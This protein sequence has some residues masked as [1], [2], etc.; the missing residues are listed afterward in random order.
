MKDLREQ[1]GHVRTQATAIWKPVLDFFHHTQ[2]IVTS[3]LMYST[4]MFALIL[5]LTAW[6]KC[7]G[8]ARSQPES[9]TQHNQ[10]RYLCQHLKGV[11]N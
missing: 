8:V 9:A 2:F 10:C 4:V 7:A 11:M 1:P 6:L 3:M 5:Q